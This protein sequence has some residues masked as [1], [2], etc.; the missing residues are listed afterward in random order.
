[1]IGYVLTFI[2]GAAFGIFCTALSAAA[3]RGED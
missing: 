1:M 2:L 3:G